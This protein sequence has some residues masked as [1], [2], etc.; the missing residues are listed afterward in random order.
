MCDALRLYFRPEDA[1]I[2][3]QNHYLY[4]SLIFAPVAELADALDL[5]SSF[6]R[7]AGSIPVRCTSKGGFLT[8]FYFLSKLLKIP[9]KWLKHWVFEISTIQLSNF[10]LS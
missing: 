4:F 1:C 10:E 5:G 7:S 9:Q 2:T 6:E 3:S 8:T